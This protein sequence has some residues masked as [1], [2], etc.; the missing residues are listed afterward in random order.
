MDDLLQGAA[1][2]FLIEKRDQPGLARDRT[3]H[4]CQYIGN[5]P[6][7]QTEDV[8][9][10]KRDWLVAERALRLSHHANDLQISPLEHLVQFLEF[11]AVH[12]GHCRQV[13]V[14]LEQGS[15]PRCSGSEIVRD[16]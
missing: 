7:Y 10:L 16:Q 1:D 3:R 4:A 15:E 14:Q 9:R 11:R 5:R 12:G 8:N 13:L 2:L 6:A